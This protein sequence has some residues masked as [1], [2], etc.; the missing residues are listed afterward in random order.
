VDFEG[1]LKLAAGSLPPAAPTGG[2]DGGA[3]VGGSTSGAPPPL[4]SPGARAVPEGG[5]VLGGA[6]GLAA[7]AAY[8][9]EGPGSATDEEMDPKIDEFMK[10]VSGWWRARTHICAHK[11]T[12]TLEKKKEM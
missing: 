2:D 11:H 6:R 7:E 10:C 4:S 9:R 5:S 8:P 3:S 1:F 12:R